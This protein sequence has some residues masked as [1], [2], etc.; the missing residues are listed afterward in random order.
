MN[1]KYCGKKFNAKNAIFCSKK[2]NTY[3]S[4]E[5]ERKNNSQSVMVTIKMDQDVSNSLREI[6]SNLIKNSTENV[7]FSQVV[8]LV[9]K[10]GIKIK[11]STLKITQT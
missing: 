8:N 3:Y 1:C 11:K 10:E 5:L 7:S 9:L 4:T 6:Q 2:C